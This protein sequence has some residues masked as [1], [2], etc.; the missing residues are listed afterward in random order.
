MRIA[1]LAVRLGDEWVTL[2]KTTN[3][4]YIYKMTDTPYVF[5]GIVI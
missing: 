4:E 2:I 5:A 1:R 3:V